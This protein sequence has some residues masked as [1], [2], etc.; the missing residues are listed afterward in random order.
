[1]SGTFLSQPWGV[2]VPEYLGTGPKQLAY[3]Y[4]FFFNETQVL[5]YDFL[6]PASKIHIPNFIP[7]HYLFPA[8]AS[9]VIFVFISQEKLH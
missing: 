1:M 5:F 4:L 8:T 6:V 2:S 7:M 9:F 3:A